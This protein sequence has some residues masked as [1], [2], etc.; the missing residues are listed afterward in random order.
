MLVKNL[1]LIAWVSEDCNSCK[2]AS[3]SWQQAAIPQEED[4]LQ[5]EDGPE[6]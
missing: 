2:R 5:E 1:A 3:R 6:G 4:Q